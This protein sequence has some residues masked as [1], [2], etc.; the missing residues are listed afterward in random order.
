MA[1]YLNSYYPIIHTSFGRNS[2]ITHAIHPLEDGS[3]RREPDFAHIFSP[4][5]GLCRPGSMKTLEKGDI[6]IYKTNGTHI[7][8]AILRITEKFDSHETAFNW[9]EQ[10]GIAIPSNNILVEP[11]PLDHSHVHGYMKRVGKM[12]KLDDAIH[13]KWNE[14]YLK[15]AIQKKSS[16]F[17][18]TESIYNA[19]QSNLKK[20]EFFSIE[21]FLREHFEK[22]PQTNWRPEKL[23]EDI[24]LKLIDLATNKV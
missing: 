11:L 9:L 12:E 19:V 4:I 6:V 16:Y 22:V 2:Q 23:D 24:G 14:E 21:P 8:T 7:L 3:I 20:T 17:F 15:R 10:N 1:I 5:S 18:L 13:K